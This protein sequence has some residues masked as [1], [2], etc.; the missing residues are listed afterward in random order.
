MGNEMYHYGVLGMRW[1]V[2]RAIR[3]RRRAHRRQ[4]KEQ[5]QNLKMQRAALKQDIKRTNTFKTNFADMTDEELNKAYA[6][7]NLERNVK[8]LMDDMNEDQY[9]TALSK[10]ISTIKLE[11]EYRNLTTPTPQKTA[12]QK[13]L[14]DVMPS[15]GKAA[16]GTVTTVGLTK[17]AAKLLKMSEKDAVKV[18]AK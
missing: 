9:S 8:R 1:G 3:Q 12:G 2:R 13:F 4:I 7:L 16:I 10:R 17:A 5:E 11:Q 6:R 15:V 14:D 18:V